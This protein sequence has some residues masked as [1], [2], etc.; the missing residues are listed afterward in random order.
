MLK[1]SSRHA[2]IIAA[3]V[4]L[5]VAALMVLPAGAWNQAPTWQPGGPWQPPSYWQPA[6]TGQ[7]VWHTI[8]PGQ[9]QEFDFNYGGSNISSQIVLGA[10][11]GT[12]VGFNV[13]TDQQ[14][15]GLVAGNT[16]IT[17]VGR[18]T[19]NAHEP[20]NLFWQAQSS[21]PEVF[22]VQVYCTISQD[23]H[24]WIELA[25][26]GSPGLTAVSSGNVVVWSP[27]YVHPG[28]NRVIVIPS[29]PT[30]Y[31]P[32]GYVWYYGSCRYNGYGRR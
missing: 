29:Q 1:M 28:N 21:S 17:P 4:A 25:G 16:S 24:F 5:L 22:H 18:G 15:K 13:Y 26:N 6:G 20:G 12:A 3:A 2:V 32:A 30:L 27:G 10:D 7:D 23:A 31:C 11:P 19:P 14:W 8:L 9:P